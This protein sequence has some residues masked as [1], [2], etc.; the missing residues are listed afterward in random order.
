MSHPA[1][2]LVRRYF[3]AYQRG[4]SAGYA[5]CWTYPAASYSGGVWRAVATPAEMARGNDEYTRVLRERGVVGGEIVSLE[6]Q[7]LGKSAAMVHGRF[8]RTDQTGAVVERVAAN[9]LAVMV[10]GDWRV[11]VCVVEAP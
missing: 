10:D 8:T 4:D 9:Y 11:A 6:V 1:A 5:D 2:E 3:A 7:D